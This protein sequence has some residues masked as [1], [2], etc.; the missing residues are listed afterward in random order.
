MANKPLSAVDLMTLGAVELRDRM[1]AGALS[2]E[3]LVTACLA[4][5]AEREEVVQAWA[6]LDGENALEQART[7]DALRKSGRPIGPL[8][9]LPV[10]IKD[11]IDTAKVPTEN[12]CT[13][14]IGRVPV[15]DASVVEKL[16][17]AGAIIMGKT[18]TTELAFMHAGKTRNPHA[19]DHTPGGSSSGSAAAVAD[20][21]V[22]LAIGTQ[23]G[24]S[25][26]RP[27][28]YC[29]VTGFK[30]SFGLISRRGILPQS[31]SLDTV[32]VFATDVAGAALLAETLAGYDVADTATT[33]TPTPRL[34][35]TASDEPPLPPVYAF[36]K[37]PGWDDAEL[38]EA[39]G[40]L[41]EA[42][43][44]QAFDV[45][46]PEVFNHAAA[47]R[48][49]INFAEMSRCYHHYW[50]D[51]KDQLGAETREAIE[52]GN[53][54]LARDYLAALDWREVLY[55]PLE[56]IF[57]RCD[58]IISPA[59]TG[60]APKGLEFTGNPV[61]NGLWT[62]LGTPA[63]TIPLLTA[64]NGLPMGVQLSGPR[65]GDG[66]LLRSARWLFDWADG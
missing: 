14:D 17:A 58:A 47:E 11:I 54:T 29:G 16:K 37:P 2:S 38:H 65:E 57:E 44:E 55:A 39:F 10:G 36:I 19:P 33:P 49:R 56:E 52:N 66:R 25:V 8:H 53:T 61:F 6:Y 60:P 27:A 34:L 41:S 3:A 50:R 1:A 7:L 13:L 12:G 18:V 28:S 4:R 22:P 26:I 35:T 9:G 15:Y 46:L 5:I 51:G 23:T 48:Q 31:P 42:L 30:P 43:G 40:Q 21:M 59:S 64:G 62:F 24:G 63:I 45:E 20:A 32:G